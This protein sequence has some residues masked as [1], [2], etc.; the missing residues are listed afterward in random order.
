MAKITI[1]IPDD[2]LWSEIF[3]SG[4]STLPWWKEA[5]FINCD[6]DEPGVVD[7]TMQD[8]DTGDAFPPRLVTV[9]TLA[10]AT[11]TVLQTYPHRNLNDMDAEL[12]DMIL[13]TAVAGKVVFG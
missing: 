6:W 4:F 2:E 3:G 11:S 12:A 13:Q 7:L 5:L 10:E 1:E 9:D 8:P